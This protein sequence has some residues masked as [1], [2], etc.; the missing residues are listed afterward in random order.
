MHTTVWLLFI[1]AGY[2]GYAQTWLRGEDTPGGGAHVHEGLRLAGGDGWVGVGH[3]LAGKRNRVSSF[4]NVI[5]R[6]YIS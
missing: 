3:T 6:V 2:P 4:N 5:H 1:F